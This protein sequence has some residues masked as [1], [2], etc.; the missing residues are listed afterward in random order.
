MNEDEEKKLQETTEGVKMESY[1]DKNYAITSRTILG[2]YGDEVTLRVP[3]RFGDIV[4]ERIGRGAFQ[5]TEDL[6][7]VILP[8]CVKSIGKNAFCK[9]RK[10][11]EVFIPGSIEE[12]EEEAFKDTSLLNE[13]IVYDYELTQEKYEYL[14]NISMITANGICIVREYPDM[15]LTKDMEKAL[16]IEP[17]A[18]IPIN[19]SAII[20]DYSSRDYFYTSNSFMEEESKNRLF[21]GRDYFSLKSKETRITENSAFIEY[22]SGEHTESDLAAYEK[23]NDALMQIKKSPFL[24]QT[25]LFMFD[26]T[27]TKK[28]KGKYYITIN[29]NCGYFYFQSARKIKFKDK[30][31]YIYRRYYLTSDKTLGLARQ[32]AAVYSDGKVVEDRKEAEQVYAKYKLLAIL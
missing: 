23:S 26:D 31:Y 8:N 12:I 28:I 6:E 27:K 4:P 5:D 20:G 13:V 29:F 18:V 19:A 2:Y 32:D 7:K 21:C 10:L 1:I 3:E 30:D 17:P 16:M 22:I 11:R 14:K 9:C 15:A 24:K 25:F